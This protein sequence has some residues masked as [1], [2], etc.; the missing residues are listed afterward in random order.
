MTIDHLEALEQDVR[1]LFVQ[2]TAD[3]T[4]PVDLAGPAWRRGRRRHHIVMATGAF[5]GSLAVV[6]VAVASV[7]V[8][9]DATRGGNHVGRVSVGASPT[10]REVQPGQV[11]VAST[12]RWATS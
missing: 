1:A 6:A 3:V 8:A 11:C 7:A 2:A 9:A 10:P 5:A 12:S 4:M